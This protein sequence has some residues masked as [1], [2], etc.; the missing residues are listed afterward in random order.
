MVV[1]Y[2]ITP[3]NPVKGNHAGQGLQHMIYEER[4][5][6]LILLS[7]EEWRLR[8]TLFQPPDERIEDGAWLF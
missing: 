8:E 1:V 4:L 5:K 3:W 2:E 6:K 7:L